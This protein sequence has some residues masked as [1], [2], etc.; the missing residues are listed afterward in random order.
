MW[1]VLGAK[2]K[3]MSS[4]HFV[5]DVGK[6]VLVPACCLFFLSVHVCILKNLFLKPLFKNNSHLFMRSPLVVC[7]IRLSSNVCVLSPMP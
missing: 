6:S 5:L 2:G 1:F 4:G 7:A 3:H